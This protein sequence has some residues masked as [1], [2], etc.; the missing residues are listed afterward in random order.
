VVVPEKSPTAGLVE[1]ELPTI[2]VLPTL[3]SSL[4]L[5]EMM[6]YLVDDN[7]D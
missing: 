4:S 2:G 5:S 3:V 1:V 6:D 7:V